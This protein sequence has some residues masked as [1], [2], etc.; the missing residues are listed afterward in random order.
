[1]ISKYSYINERFYNE[2]IKS[3]KV[4]IIYG[5]AGSGKS[6]SIA[7]YFIGLLGNK[8]GKRRAVLRKTFPSMKVS[9]YLVLKDIMFDMGIIYK[10]HRTDHYFEI[11]TNRLYYLS[12]DDPEKI[13]GAEF[14]DIW[15]EEATEFTE[16][17]FKQLMIRLSRDKS[18]ENV[19]IYLSFNPIDINHWAVKYMQVADPTKILVHH[20]TYKD[21]LQNLSQSFID[22]LEGLAAIDENFYRVYTLGQPG[23]LRNRI[24]NHF[25]IEDS[26]KWPW[27]QIK[28]SLHCYGLDFGFNHPIALCE[29]W[30]YENEFYIREL[31]YKKEQTTDDLKVWMHEH[32]IDHSDYI[33]ADS[34]EPDRIETI[35]STGTVTSGNTTQYIERFNCYPAKKDVIAG[36]DYV[37]SKRIHVSSDSLN[38]IKESQNYKFKEDK[39]GIVLEEPVKLF[40]DILDSIRYA[41]FSLNIMYG[42]DIDDDSAKGN[43]FASSVESP[44]IWAE[45]GFD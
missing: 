10:D 7:Q 21:N 36:I 13:K 31:Y 45:M 4:K 3:H 27:R 9:T 39:N 26:S 37:K 19:T 16:L 1:M 22:E 43:S 40:D 38:I 44:N 34:A 5:G 15:L 23:V 18:S 28:Q 11:G 41:L 12:L 14:A 17:D 33:F 20:S 8:D 29:V 25:S 35:N 6:I 42:L 24:Y 32:S 2:L 30:Y